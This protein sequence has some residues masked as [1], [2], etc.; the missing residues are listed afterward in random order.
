[1]ERMREMTN[2]APACEPGA[3][4]KGKDRRVPLRGQIQ[5]ALMALGAILLWSTSAVATQS[6][7][8]A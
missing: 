2:S 8:S 3:V 6:P 7:I 5:M 1:M 4:S